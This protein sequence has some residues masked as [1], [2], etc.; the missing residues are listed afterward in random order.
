MHFICKNYLL[1][2]IFKEVGISE[3]DIIFP[4]EIVKHLITN[5]SLEDGV[6]NFKRCLETILNKINILRLIKLDLLEEKELEQKIK[7]LNFSKNMEEIVRNKKIIF[8]LTINKDLIE[9]LIDNK[10]NIEEAP[11]MMYS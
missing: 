7:E 9:L 2:G 4:E 1:P 6:R 10:S 5:Y 8:P 11:F 3:E